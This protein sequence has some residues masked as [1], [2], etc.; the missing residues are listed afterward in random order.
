MKTLNLKTIHAVHFEDFK[1][2]NTEQTRDNFLLNGLEK[3]DSI[4][5]NYTHY[6]RMIAG[7]VSYTH[8]TLPTNREV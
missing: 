7:S 8:L 1:R 6:D 4:E 5:L 2:Y 3:K